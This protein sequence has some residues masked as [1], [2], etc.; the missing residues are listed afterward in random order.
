MDGCFRDIHDIRIGQLHVY[1]DVINL[2]CWLPHLVQQAHP[3]VPAGEDA[4][5]L[6]TPDA[7]YGF[8]IL[9]DFWA[10]KTSPIA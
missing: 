7:S 9:Y 10:K 8:Y 5:V 4:G 3:A 6:F 1:L 2:G